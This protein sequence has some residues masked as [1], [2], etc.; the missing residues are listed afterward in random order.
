[1]P[2]T[3]GISASALQA[4]AWSTCRPAP[5]PA[6]A[7]ACAAVPRRCSR[8]GQRK[9]RRARPQVSSC[10]WAT[11]ATSPRSAIDETL[12]MIEQ[13]KVFSLFGYVGTPTGNAVLPIVKEM[14]VPLVGAVHRCDEP[15]PAGHQAGVQRARQ[16]RRRGRDA[17]GALPG[18]GRQDGGRVLP[19]RRLRHSPCSRAPRRR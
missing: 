6:W 5:P 3:D 7:R 13:Q 16:L 2:A 15:A 14:D 11:M 1:M 12:K 18:Q 17:G 8:P 4:S 9:G 19:G 10:W